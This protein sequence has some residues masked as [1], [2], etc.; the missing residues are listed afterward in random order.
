MDEVFYVSEESYPMFHGNTEFCNWK[1]LYLGML[2][3]TIQIQLCTYHYHPYSLMRSINQ[4][5]KDTGNMTFISPILFLNFGFTKFILK[6][7]NLSYIL[8]EPEYKCRLMNNINHKIIISELV[9]SI[10]KSV[11]PN[12][13]A[14]SMRTLLQIWTPSPLLGLLAWSFPC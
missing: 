3:K 4:N 1:V 10:L 5:M 11:P 8:K 6:F 2:G 12:C 14:S 9:G 7:L 13:E